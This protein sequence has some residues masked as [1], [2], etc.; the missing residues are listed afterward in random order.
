MYCVWA[1][2]QNEV[3]T[4]RSHERSRSQSDQV[5]SKGRSIGNQ[6]LPFRKEFHVDTAAPKVEWKCI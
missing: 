3:K 5:W 2:W 4:S 6:R 1:F